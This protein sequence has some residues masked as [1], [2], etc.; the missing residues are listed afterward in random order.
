[1]TPKSK[2]ECGNCKFFKPTEYSIVGTAVGLCDLDNQT[3]GIHNHCK[4]WQQRFTWLDLHPKIKR[5]V[6]IIP[7]LKRLIAD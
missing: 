3:I 5:F 6:Q 4:N 7:F 2:R 1:M